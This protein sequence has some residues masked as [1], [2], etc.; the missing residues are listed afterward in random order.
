[1]SVMIWFG[2]L[3]NVREFDQIEVLKLVILNETEDVG[4]V[5]NKFRIVE[6]RLS[7]NRL[8]QVFG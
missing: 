4:K 7:F 1:M 3:D 6:N 5:G 8:L 2:L